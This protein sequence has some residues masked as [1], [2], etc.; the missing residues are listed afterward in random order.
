MEFE[1]KGELDKQVVVAEN[2]R[3]E[4]VIS[5]PPMLPTLVRNK[6]TGANTGFWQ[7]FHNQ[8]VLGVP[9]RPCDLELIGHAAAYAQWAALKRAQ[10]PCKNQ[11]SRR[12]YSLM[13]EATPGYV[14]RSRQNL[15]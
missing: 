11:P 2:D 12:T 10:L 13:D 8:Q 7:A 3:W 4:V 6:Q 15:T 1:L 14:L 9:L 5:P